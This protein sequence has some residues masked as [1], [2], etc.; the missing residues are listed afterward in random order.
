MSLRHFHLNTTDPRTSTGMVA[1]QL[2]R[3]ELGAQA[4]PVNVNAEET[5]RTLQKASCKNNN[6]ALLVLQLSG[7]VQSLYYELGRG[8]VVYVLTSFRTAWDAEVMPRSRP[9]LAARTH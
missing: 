8:M 7:L 9:S 6:I 3:F 1:L 5:S 4:A 2:R